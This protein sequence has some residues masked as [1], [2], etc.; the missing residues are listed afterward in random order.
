MGKNHVDKFLHCRGPRREER[1]RRIK[2][3]EIMAENF[4]NLE[5]KKQKTRHPDLGSPEDIPNK[6]NPKRTT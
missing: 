1:K 3:E 2:L 6:M 4:P 5:K